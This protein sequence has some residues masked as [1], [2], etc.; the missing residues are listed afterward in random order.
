MFIFMIITGL[1]FAF[2]MK[3]AFGFFVGLFVGS[4]IYNVFNKVAPIKREQSQ[5]NKTLFLELLFEALGA[6]CKAK[7]RVTQDDI[8]FIT[9]QMNERNFNAET[10]KLAQ[11]A[12]NRGKSLDYP[13]NERI[14]E[15][16]RHFKNDSNV[17]NFFCEQVIATAMR[18]GDL[19]QKE[20]NLILNMTDRLHLSRQ[21]VMA[22]IEI[23]R[24][25][26]G[27]SAGAHSNYGYSQQGYSRQGG[28]YQRQNQSRQQGYSYRPSK[29]DE[30]ANAYKTLGI[31]E[32]DEPQVIKRAYRKLMNEYHPDKLVSKGLPKEMLEE[33][34]KR[35]Q[36]IQAAYDLIKSER[37]F[38]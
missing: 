26:R 35:A 10:R 13:M 38:K 9:Q 14:E 6:I 1:I 36:E 20:L 29:Q 31:Q 17:L 5:E 24:I 37:Q 7:G 2:F 30:L 32:T 22:Y 21:R 28:Y 23:M 27:Y 33:A 4:L 16:Y 34:K 12:F 18:D 19:C 25:R 15:L 8:A 3:S 11:D